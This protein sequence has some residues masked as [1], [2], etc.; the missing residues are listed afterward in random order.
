[1][2][3]IYIEGYED[4]IP[5][6]EVE[7]VLCQTGLFRSKGNKA[8]NKDIPVENAN[9]DFVWIEEF[10]QSI[11][12][13]DDHFDDCLYKDD[14]I[15]MVCDRNKVFNEDNLEFLFDRLCEDSNNL[16]LSTVKTLFARVLD[17]DE[18]VLEDEEC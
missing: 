4:R 5:L 14:F 10:T 12:N 6:S 17:D 16:S 11:K 8:L 2:S 15:I 13:A 3:A 18:S 7:K 9:K 1:M